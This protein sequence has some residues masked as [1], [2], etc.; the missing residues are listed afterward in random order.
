[1]TKLQRVIDEE[2]RDSDGYWIS[3]TPGWRDCGNPGVHG[4][5]ENTKSEARR[6]ASEAEPCDCGEC[7]ELIAKV[8]RRA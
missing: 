3:L 8:T 2:Y 1:M 4:I 5:V 7:L 6:K